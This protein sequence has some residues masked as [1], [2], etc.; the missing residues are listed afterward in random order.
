VARCRSGAVV[1]PKDNGLTKTGNHW[2]CHPL[3]HEYHLVSEYPSFVL[4]C[5]PKFIHMRA[6]YIHR[7]SSLCGCHVVHHAP[8]GLLVLWWKHWNQQARVLSKHGGQ[9]NCG[10][11]LVDNLGGLCLGKCDN[12]FGEVWGPQFWM[13][14]ENCNQREISDRAC[15]IDSVDPKDI[16]FGFYVESYGVVC[17]KNFEICSESC[18]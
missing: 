9:A 3:V 12:Y 11:I 14:P 5:Y 1:R 6:T 17:A 4:P 2:F 10:F 13:H 18:W 8:E 15:G 7:T 16:C